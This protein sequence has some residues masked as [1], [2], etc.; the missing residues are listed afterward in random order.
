MRALLWRELL[1]TW[2]HGADTL[3]AVLFFVLAAS[4]FALAVGT[5]ATEPDAARPNLLLLLALLCAA[6]PLCPLAAGAG[7]RAATDA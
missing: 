7:L 1:L 4:L 3:A 5:G 2:R 6:L